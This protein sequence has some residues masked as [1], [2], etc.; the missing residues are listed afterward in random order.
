MKNPID[1]SV[2]PISKEFPLVNVNAKENSVDKNPKL[3]DQKIIDDTEVPKDLPKATQIVS[4]SL[5]KTNIGQP[6]N[7]QALYLD[8]IRNKINETGKKNLQDLLD[9]V[10]SEG[11]SEFLPNNGAIDK[12]TSNL[13]LDN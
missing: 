8:M 9:Q 12:E 1:N 6:K 3:D 2:V 7:A 10:D 13:S 4:N 5:P 11:I